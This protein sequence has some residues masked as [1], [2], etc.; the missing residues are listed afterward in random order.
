MSELWSWL[1]QTVPISGP[2]WIDLVVVL[3]ACYG[4]VE[5]VFGGAS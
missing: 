4:F 5:F 2:R 1:G 3:G